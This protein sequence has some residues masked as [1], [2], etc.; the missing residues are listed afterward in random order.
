MSAGLVGFD[1]NPLAVIAARTNYLISLGELLRFRKQEISIPVFLTDSISVTTP[2]QETLDGE[3]SEVSTTVG[4]FVVP[5]S[6]VQAKMITPVFELADQCLRNRVRMKDFE[7]KLEN[8]LKLDHSST[9]ILGRLYSKLLELEMKG[10]NR[11]WARLIKNS[12]A[13]LF[14]GRFDYVVGNPPWINWEYLP[15]EYREATKYAW[16]EYGLIR[17]GTKKLEKLLALIES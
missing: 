11:I 13:P 9:A 16:K 7:Y 8:E 3:I 6:I 4:K 15:E 14:S 10:T 1:L 5:A 12:F 17:D 2:S